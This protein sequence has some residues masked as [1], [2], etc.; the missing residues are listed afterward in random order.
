[1]ELGVE[2]ELG[3]KVNVPFLMSKKYLKSFNW[4]KSEKSYFNL[5]IIKEIDIKILDM[6]IQ[7]RSSP[8]PINVKR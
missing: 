4:I 8:Q 6:N 2:L 5:F 3:N 1:M 7:Y